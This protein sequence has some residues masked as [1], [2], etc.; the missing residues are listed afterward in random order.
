[1][2]M[3]AVIVGGAD[4]LL[5]RRVDGMIKGKVAM[6]KKKG[7][8]VKERQEKENMREN[9]NEWRCRG[10]SSLESYCHIQ[11]IERGEYEG[12]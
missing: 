10:H 5:E 1:M 3:K 8:F 7:W 2:I 6:S 9:S 4:E 12:M 11:G